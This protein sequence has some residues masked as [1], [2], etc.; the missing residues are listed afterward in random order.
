MNTKSSF[1]NLRSGISQERFEQLGGIIDIGG[2]G[3][4]VYNKEQNFVSYYSIESICNNADGSKKKSKLLSDFIAEQTNLAFMKNKL[5]IIVGVPGPVIKTEEPGSIYCPPLGCQIMTESILRC[6]G[7]VVNDTICQLFLLKP[8]L[9]TLSN[10]QYAMIT[11]GTSLGCCHF[12]PREI[13]LESVNKLCSHEFAHQEID[14]S[15][16]QYAQRIVKRNG[17]TLV[18]AF[19]VFSAGGLAECLGLATKTDRNNFSIVKKD[20]MQKPF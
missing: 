5:K 3:I 19:N 14:L 11:I 13:N 15:R 18:P 9:I 20:V 17:L 10:L 2:T 12:K 1:E 16:M 4:S 8:Q 7:L 6:G